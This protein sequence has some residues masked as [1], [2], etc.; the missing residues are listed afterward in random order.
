MKMTFWLFKIPHVYF[1]KKHDY[2]N[3]VVDKRLPSDQMRPITQSGDPT[4]PQSCLMGDQALD[5][6]END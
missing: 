4:R 1:T 2:C 5:K 6:C 3:S